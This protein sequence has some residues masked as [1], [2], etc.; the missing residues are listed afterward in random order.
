M[1][2]KKD[3]VMKLKL[4]MISA[5]LFALY[6]AMGTLGVVTSGEVE[7]F[8]ELLWGYYAIGVIFIIIVSLI[9]HHEISSGFKL[10]FKDLKKNFLK[11]LKYLFVIATIL[12]VSFNFSSMILGSS[13]KIMGND[14]TILNT[15]KYFPLYIVFVTSIYSPY[16]EEL[17]FRKS[18][19]SIFK[20]KILFIALS[21]ILYGF[22]HQSS[23]LSIFTFINNWG[24]ET[25]LSST[26]AVFPYIL[27]GCA[28]S[29]IYIKEKNIVFPIAIKFIYNIIATIVAII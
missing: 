25:L 12:F 6:L 14:P 26:I 2:T 8:R 16:V 19:H 11:T 3:R 20:N 4:K 15:F 10:Y 5:V 18:L 7:A 9:Y 21:G 28:L 1:K 13:T 24:L 17:I 23:D 22:F 27:F 29:Y